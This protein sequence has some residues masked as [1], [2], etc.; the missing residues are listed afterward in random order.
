[1]I[2]GP[3]GNPRGFGG[4]AIKVS[5]LGDD[6]PDQTLSTYLELTKPRALA[7][8]VFTTCMTF[9]I[10]ATDAI[11]GWR[12][13]HTAIGVAVAAGG[14]L[15]LNQHM[16]AGLDSQMRRTRDRPIP[17]GRISRRAAFVF[18]MVAMLG[19]YAYL[20][21][22]VNPGCSVATMLCGVSYLYMYTP[23]KRRTSFSSFVGAIP[24]AMLPIM[25]WV[26][27]RDRLEIGAWILFAIL[28]LWQIPH[29]LVISIRHKDDYESAGMRQLP[30][31]SHHLT[32]RRQ[33]AL[34]V[35][36]LIPITMLPAFV[37]MTELFYPVIALILGFGLMVLAVRY[38]LQPTE[39]AAKRMFISLSAY[40]PLLLLAMYLDK[41]G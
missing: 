3:P 7:M 1:M 32:S 29:A 19:G 6:L 27:A 16:E 2:C 23:M 21:I 38:M 39:T 4:A 31:I 8:I 13:A 22:L 25:G 11:V 41:P 33:L 28:F 20:W 40:L 9:L 14:A 17:S 15:A 37:N 5:K 10:A 24:G 26:A 36:L 18:G 12:L 30:I 35:I 34:N